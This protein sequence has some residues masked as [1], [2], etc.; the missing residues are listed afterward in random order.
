[1]VGLARRDSMLVL[2]CGCVAS[3]GL[4]V[5]A[6]RSEVVSDLVPVT[7]RLAALSVAPGGQ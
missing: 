7:W 4:F 2:L 3:D 6:R 5:T 1:M